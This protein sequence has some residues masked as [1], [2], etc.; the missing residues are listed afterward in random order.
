MLTGAGLQDLGTL[1][2]L[3]SVANDVN[4]A[5]EV[6]GYA[7]L[8]GRPADEW[9]AFV[10]RGQGMERLQDLLDASGSGWTQLYRAN[11]INDSG[12]IVGT[13]VLDGQWRSFVATP[14]AR[15]QVAEP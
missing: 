13:G 1:G 12:V 9:H 11:A 6:V 14:L 3:V 15:R 5:R 7:N 10:H 8:A 4:A 2:G